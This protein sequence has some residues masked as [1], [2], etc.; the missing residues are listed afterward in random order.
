MANTQTN[1]F[2]ALTACSDFATS[3]FLAYRFIRSSSDNFCLSNS[4]ASSE[5]RNSWSLRGKIDCRKRSK[6][7]QALSEGRPVPVEVSRRVR[8]RISRVCTDTGEGR[9]Q[10][11]VEVA[12]RSVPLKKLPSFTTC[13]AYLANK[14]FVSSLIH[15]LALQRCSFVSSL[16]T[17]S[18][19]LTSSSK[20]TSRVVSRQRVCA[21]PEP[22]GAG[23]R[24]N[25]SLLLTSRSFSLSQASRRWT[26]F[27]PIQQS[28]EQYHRSCS[29]LTGWDS[30][31]EHGS[32]PCARIF[33]RPSR[34]QKALK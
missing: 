28:Y 16:A 24:P 14:L 33:V 30:M 34:R 1:S 3:R 20:V 10:S 4:A 12:G 25:P 29:A 2:R 32:K 27:L 19:I 26:S 7:K 18:L 8:R 5:K 9:G 11:N 15:C 13:N 21:E 22:A 31:R 23:S 6:G 17:C